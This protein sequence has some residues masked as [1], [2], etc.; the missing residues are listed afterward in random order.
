MVH[1][2]LEIHG[3]PRVLE[4]GW[5][6]QGFTYPLRTSPILGSL[7]LEAGWLAPGFTKPLQTSP[8]LGSLMA[9]SASP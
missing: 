4:A 9:S 7:V 2:Y 8:I 6:A 5:L 3:Y 1:G